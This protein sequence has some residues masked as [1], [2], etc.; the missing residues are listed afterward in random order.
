MKK[1]KSDIPRRAVEHLVREYRRERAIT[2]Y[3]KMECVLDG[4]IAGERVYNQ[5]GQLVIERPIKSGRTHGRMYFWNDDGTLGL[6]EPYLEGKVHG[7]ARQYGRKGKIIGKYK[8]V[9]G[10]GFDVWRQE[11]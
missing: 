8:L 5:D 4:K 7:I 2:H 11:S 9:H 1:S 10:T 3:R 6:V